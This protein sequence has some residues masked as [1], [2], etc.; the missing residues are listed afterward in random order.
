MLPPEIFLEIYFRIKDVDQIICFSSTCRQMRKILLANV[1]NTKYLS[2]AVFIFVVSSILKHKDILF[3]NLD[4]FH[5]NLLKNNLS[6]RYLIQPKKLK[7]VHRKKENRNLELFF[8]KNT[9][10]IDLEFRILKENE[11]VFPNSYF[12]IDSDKCYNNKMTRSY[13]LTNATVDSLFHHR[14]VIYCK[15]K[16]LLKE[17]KD[18]FIVKFFFTICYIHMKKFFNLKIFGNRIIVK[19]G[20][21]FKQLRYSLL[22]KN[23]FPLRKVKKFSDI[24][25]FVPFLYPKI[26]KIQFLPLMEIMIYDQN[27]FE[28]LVTKGVICDIKFYRKI[29]FFDLEKLMC[30][31]I[32]SPPLS[33]E[34]YLYDKLL[35]IIA[36][37]YRRR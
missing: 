25:K 31:H 16:K 13:L 23:I 20:E 9:I 24:I 17:V 15:N 5:E 4:Y 11:K 29:N 8:I 26:E 12:L 36:I 10:K 3:N 37:H 14:T 1:K 18:D 32:P 2:D 6:K 28:E 21:H 30:G 19:N 7:I 27:R 34:T 35:S 22:G 33:Y